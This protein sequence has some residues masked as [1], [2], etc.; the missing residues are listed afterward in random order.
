[1]KIIFTVIIILMVVSVC[2]ASKYVG[3][4]EYDFFGVSAPTVEASATYWNTEMTDRWTDTM[5][6]DNLWTTTMNTEIP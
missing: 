4:D 5:I 6:T 3:Y 1:M 2:Y